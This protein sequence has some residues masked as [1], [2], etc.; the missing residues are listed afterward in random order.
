[1]SAPA[2]DPPNPDYMGAPTADPPNPECPSRI[3]AER[4]DFTVRIRK[5]LVAFPRP[6]P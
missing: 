2:A 5:A 4:V 3:G 6:R 1:M